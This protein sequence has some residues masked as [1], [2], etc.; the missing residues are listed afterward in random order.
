MMTKKQANKPVI[1]SVINNVAMAL[2]A[3]GIV[4]ITTG[5]ML[6]YIPIAFSIGIEWF[7]YWGRRKYW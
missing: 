5:S 3:Y 7:K 2:T 4:V 6:G 1:E